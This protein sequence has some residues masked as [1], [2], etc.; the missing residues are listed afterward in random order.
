MPATTEKPE[1]SFHSRCLLCG[2]LNP[3]SLGLSFTALENGEVATSY[4]APDELQGY[5]GIL[6][7][8]II[9]SLLDAAMTHCL[10]H[11]GVRALT[12]DLQIRFLQPVPCGVPLEL[13]ARVLSSRP[14]LYRLESE[15]ILN[16]GVVARAR[17]RF[18]NYKR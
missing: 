18:M 15:L 14:P 11:R 8:G 13:R 6:H 17:A 2:N 7:G 5:D 16:D 12:G 1:S 10:F 4:R 3:K 9:A